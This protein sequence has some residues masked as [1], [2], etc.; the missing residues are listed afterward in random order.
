MY[1][2]RTDIAAGMIEVEVAGFWT[3][4]EV[5]AFGHDVG[6][7]ARTIATTGASH[8]LL[9][10]YSKA[11]IQSQEVVT[12]FQVLVLSFPHKSRKLALYTTG[13]FARMQARRV[14][15]LRDTMAVFDDRASALEWLLA[16][17]IDRC[18]RMG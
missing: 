4:D 17:Q 16:D 1:S 15:R 10:D 18:A 9:C 6:E 11:A 3:V 12:A 5:K 7:A 14:A 13:P 8:V 2:I